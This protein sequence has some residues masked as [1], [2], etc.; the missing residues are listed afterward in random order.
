MIS[1]GMKNKLDNDSLLDLQNWAVKAI[2]TPLRLKK[3]NRD[4][5]NL[6]ITEIYVKVN[7]VFVKQL[8]SFLY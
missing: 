3:D 2:K 7:D 8:S 5:P 1:Q 4:C 6:R